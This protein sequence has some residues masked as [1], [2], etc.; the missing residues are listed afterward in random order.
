MRLIEKIVILVNFLIIHCQ[1]LYFTVDANKLYW[2]P[3]TTLKSPFVTFINDLNHPSWR[4]KNPITK[5]SA[6]LRIH[7]VKDI[8]FAAACGACFTPSRL[9]A[10]ITLNVSEHHSVSVPITKKDGSR[11]Y[12]VGLNDCLIIYFATELIKNDGLIICTLHR[13]EKLVEE[14]VNFKAVEAD[15]EEEETLL[16]PPSSSSSSSSSP[17]HHHYHHNNYPLSLKCPAAINSSTSRSIV[18]SWYEDFGIDYD[19]GFPI[20]VMKS[21]YIL[22]QRPNFNITIKCSAYDILN[23]EITTVFQTSY[24]F[25]GDGEKRD[26]FSSKE[27]ED[28]NDGLATATDR[29][30]ERTKKNIGTFVGILVGI[31]CLIIICWCLC[32]YDA[33]S[34][35]I[36]PDEA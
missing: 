4:T 5:E 34:N 25:F 31:T 8:P 9:N 14:R 3:I 28:E 35:C 12:R 30:V 33:V 22:Y 7:L 17:H 23:P 27:D 2:A 16:P 24:K 11:L 6:Y 36:W 21:S 32:D 19:I 15:I 20:P 29:F 18:Y 1:S 13:G 10:T 26:I